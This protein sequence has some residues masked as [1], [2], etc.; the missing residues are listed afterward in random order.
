TF[1]SGK[2]TIGDIVEKQV[3]LGFDENLQR[4]PIIVHKLLQPTGRRGQRLEGAI[5]KWFT[6]NS[7][8][9]NVAEGDI[10]VAY[11][12]YATSGV[13]LMDYFAKNKIPF[14]VHIHGYDITSTTKNSFYVLR[15]KRLFILCDRF[16]VASHHI[17]RLLVLLGCDLGK[18]EVIRHGLDASKIV[19]KPWIERIK[20]NPSIVFLGRLTGKKSPLS[21]IHAFS[22]VNRQMD[23]VVLKIIGDGP[24]LA[25]TKSLG[26]N[27]G[28]GD[29]ITFYGALPRKQSFPIL[30]ESWIYAQHSVTSLH[31]DQEGYAISPA[32]AALHELPVI[33]TIHN[34]IPEHVIDGTTGFLVPEFNFELMAEKII[35]L[36]KNPKVAEN[37]GKE[38]RKN[39]VKLNNMNRRV[40]RISDILSDLTV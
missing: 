25:E 35:E 38:G 12:D 39:I 40:S 33:S 11:V 31:G 6:E 27:L 4:L 3:G 16:I 23:N 24:L 2:K 36:L 28:L 15:L 30:N 13:L 18:I 14:V 29:K 19:P 21:L 32:E 20:D 5:K 10:D 7:L 34:G 37:M 17:K 1:Y 26:D 8:K 9:K 22:I